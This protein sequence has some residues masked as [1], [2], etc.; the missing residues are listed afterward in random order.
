MKVTESATAPLS[1][2]QQRHSLDHH[3]QSVFSEVLATVG[4]EGYQTASPIAVP[5][6][7]DPAGDLPTLDQQAAGAWE[8]W[9]DLQLTGRYRTVATSP[10]VDHKQLQQDFGDVITRAY[11]DGGYADPK[12]FLQSL[13]SDKMETIRQIHSLADSINVSSLS[14][15]G[16]LNL[17]IPPVAQ[18]DL[19]FDG[20]TQSGAAYGIRFPDSRTPADVA[21][22]WNESTADLSEMDKAFYG[23][24]AKLPTLLANIK[25]HPD[26]TFS[27][28]VEPGD[29]EYSNPMAAEDYSYGQAAQDYVNYLDAFRAQIDPVRYQRDR[30]FWTDFASRLDGDR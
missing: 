2:S 24:V 14:D 7:D 1:L 21:E 25:L 6:G 16:A 20:L 17:L 23:L 22:A 27:H 10:D 30:A 3:V 11:N 29:P 9:F 15:E 19:N 12:S 8:D 18:V 28:T 5:S 26:G 13:P 4:V